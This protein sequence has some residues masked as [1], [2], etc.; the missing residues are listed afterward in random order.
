M[1]STAGSKP[2][3]AIR[4][5]TH[6]TR[7]DVEMEAVGVLAAVGKEH[8]IEHVGIDDDPDLA[9]V[10]GGDGTML[11][12][13]K[14]YLG[15]NVPVLGVNFGRVGYLTSIE[16]E[17]L[18]EGL[19]RVFEGDFRT[20]ELSTLE[21]DV[22]GETHVAVNDVVFTSSTLGRM[23]E[24]GWSIGGEDLGVVGCDGIVCS[25]PSGSTAYNL[26]NGGPVLVWGLDAMA[27]T[28]VAPHSLKVRPLVVPRGLDLA[29]ANETTH[30]GLTVLVDGVAVGELGPAARATVR[31]GDQV[32]LLA[33]LPESTFFTRY[34]EHF[35]S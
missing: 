14:H 18:A 23:V 21:L 9:V 24:I 10:L 31:L 13:L 33:T 35:A 5:V 2:Q 15:A 19:A 8:G 12:A 27:V 1:R 11:K 6:F 30:T 20:I 16:A 26:S 28:L 32:T 29:I 34:R 7:G 4:K 17:E 22:G 25:T 3:S